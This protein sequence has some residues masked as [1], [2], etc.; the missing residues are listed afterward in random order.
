VRRL[1]RLK[2]EFGAEPELRDEWGDVPSDKGPVKTEVWRLK[3]KKKK[4][5]F[6]SSPDEALPDFFTLLSQKKRSYAFRFPA[7]SRSKPLSLLPRAQLV[8]DVHFSR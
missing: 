6:S 3:K 5:V 4:T 2:R 7:L 8:G 1:L